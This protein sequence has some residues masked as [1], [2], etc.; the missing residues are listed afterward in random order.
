MLQLGTLAAASFSALRALV[1]ALPSD[2]H[3]L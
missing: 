1:L 3:P 2:Q